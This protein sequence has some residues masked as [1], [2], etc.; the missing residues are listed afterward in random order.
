MNRIERMYVD[1]VDAIVDDVDA[2]LYCDSDSDCE[3]YC[4]LC[5]DCCCNEKMK[6]KRLLMKTNL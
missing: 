1:A 3:L 2:E 4:R 6:R 5:C